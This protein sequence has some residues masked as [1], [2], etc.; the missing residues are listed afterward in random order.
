MTAQ[1]DDRSVTESPIESRGAS[2]PRGKLWQR[3]Q[4]LSI[5]SPILLALVLFA[6]GSAV[7][8]NFTSRDNIDSI[9]ILASFLGICSAGQTLV[10]ILGGIDLSVASTI[11]MGEVVT[12]VEYSRGMPLWQIM[13]ILVVAGVL[14]GFLNGGI[15]SYF[16]VHPLIVSLGVSFVI[17]GAI[18]IW[19]SGASAQG[20]S[21]HVFSMMTSIR[22][23]IGPIPVPPVLLVWVAVAAIVIAIQRRTRLGRELYALGSNAEAAGL[24]LA[25]R[26]IVWIF[27][28]A[29]SALGG[30]LAGVLL[31]GF[32]GGADFSAGAPYLFYSIAA[33][34]VGGTSLLGGSG[35]YG[36]TIVGSIV[37]I[38]ITTILV[39][40]GFS[41]SLQETMLGIFIILVVAVVGR[42]VHVRTRV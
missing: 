11:G 41:S 17:S 40:I 19:T 32:S 30:L 35:G 39:G 29:V 1:S 36:R 15:S 13:L 4:S 24:A 3:V 20:V 31:S 27:T 2:F 10:I 33:V 42:E 12:S 28:Y 38:E 25:R 6:V 37:I 5:L 8:S 14:I 22:S 9:L 23:T 16:N 34:V 7:V 18:L 21:P 26:K